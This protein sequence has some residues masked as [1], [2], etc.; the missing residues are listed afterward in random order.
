[1]PHKNSIC[2]LIDRLDPI[3]RTIGAVNTV[4]N[5]DGVLTGHNTDWIGIQRPLEKRGSLSTRSVAVL[6]AGGAAQA[7][8]Y[9]CRMKGATVTVFSRDAHKAH[10]LATQHGTSWGTLD[11][12]AQLS[13]FDIIINAT[14]V[15]MGELADQSPLTISQLH[16]RQIVFETIYHP[17]QTKLL[18]LAKQ[19]GCDIV[20]GSEMFLEQGAAQFEI[21]TGVQAPRDVMLRALGADT[22]DPLS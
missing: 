21:L 1:M 10:A 15:G 18:S 12:S 22:S 17:R 6:G 9:A 5:L 11:A 16:N 2:E 13:Q 19:L 8:V 14:P 3:A 20:Y 4:T 7:A